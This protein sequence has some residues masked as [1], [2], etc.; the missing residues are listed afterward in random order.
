[1]EKWPELTVGSTRSS[2][3]LSIGTKIAIIVIT[4]VLYTIGKW[5]TAFIPT[6]WGVGELLVGIFLPAY[7]AVTS[8]TLPVAIGAGLGTF[9]GDFFVQTN[10]SLSLVAGVPANFL[11]FLLFGWFVK[12]YKS[13]PSFVAG[14]VIFVS[15]GNLM[16]AILV[17]LF[18]GATIGGSL[19]SSAIMGL[20]VF[21][22]TTS[23]PAILIGVPILVRG[24]RPLYGRTRILTNFP[25]WP[26]SIGT[27]GYVTAIAFS[28]AYTGVGAAV[29]FLQP[30]SVSVSPGL[31]YFVFAA[32]LVV[33][34]GS[35]SSLLAGASR[36]PKPTTG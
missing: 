11:A 27:R 4:T 36:H 3:I 14:T 29:F 35:V 26:S 32:L 21:W 13:W 22:N 31:A 17:F 5:I 19:P 9:V 20:T 24:T 28:V 10:L 25:Q 23:I 30:S 12:K 18:I 6:P 34:F 16:A 1:M 2:N 15:L 7:M 8:D 33:V